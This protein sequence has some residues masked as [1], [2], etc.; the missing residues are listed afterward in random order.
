MADQARPTCRF[1]S[2][3]SWC[4]FRGTTFLDK[5]YIEVQ[6]PSRMDS[7][8]SAIEWQGSV[9]GIFLRCPRFFGHFVGRAHITFKSN[10][11]S[12]CSVML[13]YLYDLFS[14][15]VS[16]IDYNKYQDPWFVREEGPLHSSSLNSQHRLCTL[17]SGRVFGHPLKM[18]SCPRTAHQPLG[19]GK[20]PGC[21]W[22]YMVP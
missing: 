9:S 18:T 1:Q 19:A 22:T 11:S 15:I 2:I 16:K 5:V 17:R 12:A 4:F 13:W 10:L 8:V 3:S 20:S 7:Q 21:V 6:V 14:G